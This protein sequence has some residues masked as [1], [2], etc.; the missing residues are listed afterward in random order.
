MMQRLF[1]TIYFCFLFYIVWGIPTPLQ[2][3]L[4][5]NIKPLH[6]IRLFTTAFIHGYAPLH[7]IFANLL[8]NMLLTLPIGL[9]LYQLLGRIPWWRILLWAI[10]LPIF[11]EWGQLILHLAGYSTRTVDIDDVLLNASGI[12]IGYISARLWDRRKQQKQG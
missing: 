5:I 1:Y 2:D 7:V 9:L 8:G 4:I 10:T 12:T 11:L 3:V 6:T